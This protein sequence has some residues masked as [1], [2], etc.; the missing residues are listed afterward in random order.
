[1]NKQKQE[2]IERMEG[3]KKLIPATIGAINDLPDVGNLYTVLNPGQLRIQVDCVP[4]EYLAL[5][6]TLAKK[7]KYIGHRF[8]ELTG[9]YYVYFEHRNFEKVILA[10]ELE[11]PVEFENGASCRL[12][13]TGHK[14]TPL[15]GLECK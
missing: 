11:F 15:Y 13:E 8:S 2:L 3:L 12:V 7:W 10:L 4:T 5:R 6:R 9:N 14:T 1:M